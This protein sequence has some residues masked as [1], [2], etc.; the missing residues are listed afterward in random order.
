LQR[1]RLAVRRARPPKAAVCVLRV[2]SRDEAGVLITVIT[3]SDVSMR[4]PGQTRSVA[5]ATE[6]LS[7]VARFLA[8]YEHGEIAGT[9][10]S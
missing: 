7:L 10:M 5:N 2:E 9:G 1:R 6:A 4:S 3:T 8:D